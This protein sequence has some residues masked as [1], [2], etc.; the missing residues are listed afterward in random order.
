MLE[1][2][3]SNKMTFNKYEKIPADNW[4]SGPVAKSGAE[5]VPL[6]GYRISINRVAVAAYAV[7][8]GLPFA[9]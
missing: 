8:C 6:S 4:G 3:D 1:P 7:I 5:W 9:E 2:K